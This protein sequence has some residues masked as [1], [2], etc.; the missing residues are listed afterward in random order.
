MS[1]A[2]ICLDEQ[3]GAVLG[4]CSSELRWAVGGGSRQSLGQGLLSKHVT[5][6]REGSHGGSGFIVGDS[7]TSGSVIRGREAPGTRAQAAATVMS[8]RPV[9]SLLFLAQGGSGVSNEGR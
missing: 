8:I 2:Q 3:M 9:W 5:A 1:G 6:P 7:G 4:P